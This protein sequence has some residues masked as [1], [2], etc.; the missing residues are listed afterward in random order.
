VRAKCGGKRLVG[1]HVHQD[2]IPG[3]LMNL[4]LLETQVRAAMKRKELLD[5]MAAQGIPFSSLGDLPSSS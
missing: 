2:H 5:Y 4:N 3:L 1:V